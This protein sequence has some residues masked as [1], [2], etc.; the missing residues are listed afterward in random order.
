MRKILLTGNKWGILPAD[1][2]KKQVIKLREME[3]RLFIGSTFWYLFRFEPYEYVTY[4]KI[5][6][7]NVKKE[8][9]ATMWSMSVIHAS[10]SAANRPHF[11][12]HNAPWGD[13]ALV[14]HQ[15]FKDH[16]FC[17][18]HGYIFWWLFFATKFYWSFLIFIITFLYP[19]YRTFVCLLWH[20]C[21]FPRVS[22]L[23]YLCSNAVSVPLLSKWMKFL[24]FRIPNTAVFKC[25]KKK[26]E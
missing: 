9:I 24:S 14:E 5:M 16:T 2:G 12:T 11:P 7:T 6:K 18:F 8:C 4:S 22:L 13:N 21:I 25:T 3:G 26:S 1:R 23:Q 20:L 17:L 10:G 15:L 19:Y